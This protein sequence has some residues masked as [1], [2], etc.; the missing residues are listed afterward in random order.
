MDSGIIFDFCLGLLCYGCQEKPWLIQ[1]FRSILRTCSLRER[2]LSELFRYSS[3]CGTVVAFLILLNSLFVQR[4]VLGGWDP[5]ARKFFSTDELTFTVP[6][7]MFIQMI[8]R[9]SESFMTT[10]TWTTVQKK[11][12]LS[13]RTWAPKTSK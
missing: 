6:Y 10:P 3:N 1:N 9:F 5:S 7:E 2:E 12:Q 13:N 8:E 4:A 11:I